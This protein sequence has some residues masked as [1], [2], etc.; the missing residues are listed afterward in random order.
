MKRLDMTLLS[1]ATLLTIVGICMLLTIARED[2]RKVESSSQLG[3][4]C[5]YVGEVIS[6]AVP[7]TPEIKYDDYLRHDIRLSEEHQKLL[8][9]ACQITGCEYD[10]ALAVCWVETGMRNLVGDSGS[11]LGYMQIQPRWVA[12]RMKHYGVSNLMDPYSNFLI[13][14]SILADYIGEHGMVNGL[15]KYNTGH[16][17][18]SS[19][20]R[21]VLKY[22]E[23]LWNERS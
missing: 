10:V 1:M 22:R 4:I 9:E 20:A 6:N 3:S 2:T 5:S 14:T 12:D 8:W 11:S 7:E 18:E 15:T 17:G 23:A 21:K 13:G 19:Y 16:I